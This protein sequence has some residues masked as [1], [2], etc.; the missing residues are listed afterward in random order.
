MIAHIAVLGAGTMGFSIAKLFAIHHYHVALYEPGRIQAAEEKISQEAL[1]IRLVTDLE[2]AVSFADLVIECVPE[3][4]Q[5]KQP[6]YRQ[7]IPFLK[8]EAI[9][10]SNTST[11]SL[12]QLAK[13]LPYADRIVI[14]HFF[15][16]AHVIPLVEL[17][18][19]AHTD[20]AILEKLAH[21]L[22]K[23]GKAPV[24]LNQDIPGFIAN[25][26]QAALMRE[27][28]FLL[29]S[30]IASAE[31]ID[32]VVRNG[33]GLRWALK[34]PFQIADLGGL[35]IWS[36]VTGHLFPSL[37]K[38]IEPPISMMA[39]IARGELGV[40]SGSGYYNYGGQEQAAAQ[41]IDELEQLLAYLKPKEENKNDV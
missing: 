2:E 33:L 35:D 10:A 11:F 41:M 4:L 16:P 22:R 28:S 27:A 19:L 26:L 30:G 40:K 39:K 12:Q 18:G 38:N 24:V 6:L 34:G 25:R 36:K 17:I 23:V 20:P 8:P 31:D 14:A 9:V 29:E 5:I 13:G 15:N 37:D 3:D 21:L 7:L 1:P 32:S